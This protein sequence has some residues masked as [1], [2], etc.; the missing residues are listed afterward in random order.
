MQSESES[1]DKAFE[2]SSVR[3][4]RLRPPRLRGGL[5]FLSKR[6]MCTHC[7][8][9]CAEKHG[10]CRYISSASFSISA[11]HEQRKLGSALSMCTF[12]NARCKYSSSSSTYATFECIHKAFFLQ[13]FFFQSFLFEAFSSKNIEGY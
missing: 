13:S 5:S 1:Q 3:R 12:A 4:L 11:G 10:I 7:C 9:A 8:M 6:I 2:R